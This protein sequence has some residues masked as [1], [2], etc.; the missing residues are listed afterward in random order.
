MEKPNNLILG[1]PACC[2]QAAPVKRSDDVNLLS[3]AHT[4]EG[5]GRQ[6]WHMH[7]P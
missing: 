7:R 5:I 1:I 2:Y 3:L 4:P 6:N